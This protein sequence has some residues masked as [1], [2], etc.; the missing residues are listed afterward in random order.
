MDFRDS[1][2]DA[3][4]RAT[5][6]AFLEQAVAALPGP[7]P[8]TMEER[9]PYWQGWQRTLADGGY[10][11]LSWSA[12]HG[13]QE[14]TLVQQAIFLEE[15]DRAGAPDRLN[16][17]GE[18]L[19]GPTLIDFGTDAQRERFLRPILRGDSVWCQLFSEP[20]AGSDLA[21]LEARA[22]RD[23]AAGG[24]RISGQKV[25]TSRAQIADHGMLLARTGPPGSRHGGITYFLLPMRQDGVTVRGLRHILGEPEF[26]EVFLDDA[27]VPDDLV[28]GPVDGG[29]KIAMATLGYERVILA[30]GRVN[31]QRLFDDLVAEIR[32]SGTGDDPFVRRTM[33]DLHV[34]TRVYR[35]NGLR[36]L[37]AMASGTPGPA[38]SL[39]KLLSGPLLEDMADFA[40]AR[41]GLA[42]QLD[43]YDA[44]D[45]QAARWLK[46]A[47]Q[48][49][50]TAIAGGTTFIQK[51]IVAERVLRLPRA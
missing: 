5:V 14:A 24:W 42:G 23:E 47:Y 35:L 39:G 3:A 41:H 21:A 6:R 20:G 33:A 29:W 40:T 50:G 49:R 4:Y 26:N 16:I 45:A 15:Y 36:A 43:P 1:P 8:A 37:S 51:N 18:N 7:E 2:Q 27:F 19:C 44:D 12:A 11:G 31:M 25:W 38:S 22:V 13:G 30:T 48:A 10:A 17:L 34:R 46:L 9:L 32:A 28:L